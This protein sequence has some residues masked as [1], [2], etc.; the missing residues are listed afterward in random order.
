MNLSSIFADGRPPGGVV[1]QKH[2]VV[3][4]EGEHDV[5]VTLRYLQILH[6]LIALP[7][8]GAYDEG[9]LWLTGTECLVYL[10]H[11][12][13]PLFVF[14]C[15]GF[16]HELISHPVVAVAFQHVRQLVPKVDEILL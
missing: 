2:R 12:L 1:G 9:A 14:L 3:V 13:V 10:G 11:Q 7:T 15:Y 6:C 5:L 8:V 16:V 4:V